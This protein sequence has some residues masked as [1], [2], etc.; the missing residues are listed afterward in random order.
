VTPPDDSVRERKAALRAQVL[1]RRTQRD[2]DQR[3]RLG[4]ELAAS[5]RAL[6][7]PATV[8]GYVGVG[9]EP[10]TS[11]LLDEL[12]RRGAEVL[13]PVVRPGRV[14]DWASGSADLVAGPLGLR[15]PAGPYLGPDAVRDAGLVLVPALAVDLAGHRL[16]RGGGYYDRVLATVPRTAVLVAV[17]FDDEVLDA[18]PGEA[19][20]VPVDGVLTPSGLRMFDSARGRAQPAP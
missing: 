4:A 16:G 12:R 3:L 13:L 2:D 1:A 8:A 20:D 14:L 15:E 11:A 6:T 10:P 5:S 18:V 19:H 7:V 17:V 9:S